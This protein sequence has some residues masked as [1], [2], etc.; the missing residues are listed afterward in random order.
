MKLFTFKTGSE[1]LGIDAKS[2]YRVLDEVKITPVCLTPPC[3]PGLLYHRGELLDVVDIGILLEKGKA[4]FEE[5]RRLVILRWS[6]KALAI[7]PGAI[8]GLIWV[9]NDSETSTVFT[10][11]GHSV[12]IITQ[13]RFGTNY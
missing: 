12:R 2:V 13:K 7:A 5:N 3:Y 9:E 8:N 4:T 6:D 1:H 11:G 10:A